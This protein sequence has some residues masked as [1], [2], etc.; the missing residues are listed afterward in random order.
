M[1]KIF[2]AAA[3]AATCSANVM[4]DSISWDAPWG[5]SEGNT[6]LEMAFAYNSQSLIADT[7]NDNVLSAGDTIHSVGGFGANGFDSAGFPLTG[8]GYGSIGFN[9][10][11]GFTPNP[12]PQ[13]VSYGTDY[14][15][16]FSFNDLMGTYNGS[17]FIY[18]SGT[19]EFGVFA[20][21]NGSGLTAGFNAL[22]DVDLT[23]GGP[24]NSVGQQKQ[25]FNGTV[26]N[27]D[28]DADT[29]FEINHLGNIKSLA[30]WAALGDVRL[31]SSQTVDGGLPGL[32]V[33]ITDVVFIN[34]VG[35]VAAQHKGGLSINVPEPTS[36]A[37]LGLGLGLLG[38]AGARCRKS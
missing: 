31:S 14:L 10:V 35:A 3:F 26:S 27:F 37:I 38:F 4:A 7:N 19:I 17:D 25:V 32:P 1:K 13:I 29:I 21:A 9:Q 6:I 28:H 23:Y 16:T 33:N 8:Q 22:F 24:D 12:F 18:T 34:G 5:D 20:A 2:F 15:F 30:D 11:N 36:I